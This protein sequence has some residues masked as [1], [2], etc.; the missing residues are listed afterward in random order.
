MP[1]LSECP[2][3][4]FHVCI[5]HIPRETIDDLRSTGVWRLPETCC[6]RLPARLQ[7]QTNGGRPWACSLVPA[8]GIFC[9]SGSLFLSDLANSAPCVDIETSPHCDPL[10]DLFNS[11]SSLWHSLFAAEPC[12]R[13]NSA[14]MG[15][16]H[17]RTHFEVFAHRIDLCG[18]RALCG[19]A[20]DL[21]MP[22]IVSFCASE[23][24][25]HR[26]LILLALRLPFN[27]RFHWL[28]AHILFPAAVSISRSVADVPKQMGTPSS[29]R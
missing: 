21:N 8:S 17:H 28:A 13:G 4:L 7:H 19:V 6:S 5:F 2:A 3:A 10:A 26:R 11:G 12:D 14:R 27:M 29:P 24:I 22:V 20:V 1:E 23:F 25:L 15:F 18:G 16:A 9:Q